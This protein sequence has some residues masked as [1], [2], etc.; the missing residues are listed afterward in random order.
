MGRLSHE[1]RGAPIANHKNRWEPLTCAYIHDRERI[2][3][4]LHPCLAEIG[5]REPEPCA[6]SQIPSVR[7]MDPAGK[8]RNW[9][10][11]GHSLQALNSLAYAAH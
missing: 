4:V 5:A 2:S 3:N 11:Y 7:I 10:Q 1:S 8:G 6:R 9:R